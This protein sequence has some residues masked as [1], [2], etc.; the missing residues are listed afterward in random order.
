MR[1]S[2][3]HRKKLKEDM[4]YRMIFHDN[5]WNNAFN[6]GCKLELLRWN[7]NLTQQQ[8]AEKMGTHQSAIARAELEGCSFEFLQRAAKIVGRV[9]KVYDVPKFE[10]H[11]T[12][13]Y[14]I[15]NSSTKTFLLT[16]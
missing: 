9:F 3:Y 12:V 5:Q 11:P 10:L 13:D 1:V 8:L 16:N 15:D 7:A 6:F 4:K 14:T 2:D